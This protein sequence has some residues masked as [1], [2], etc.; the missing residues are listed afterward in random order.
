MKKGQF[1]SPPDMVHAVD[2]A[3][4]LGA[5][6]VMVTERGVSF[7]YNNLV[8]DM[9]GLLQMRDF[10]PVCFDATHSVQYPGSAVGASGGDR[11]FV[12]PLARAA[13]AAGID[14]LF[15]EV[16]SRPDS[17]P[18]DGPSQISWGT[19]DRL[20]VQVREIE[21]ALSRKI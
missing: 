6:G 4:S 20:L 9:R 5:S 8:V 16:H 17:A 2:K 7:G 1:I 13:T 14:A 18:C 21:R 11:R 10:A 3:R 12:E 15:V 19:L